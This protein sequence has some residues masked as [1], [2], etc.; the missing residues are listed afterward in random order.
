MDPP[1]YRPV[2]AGLHLRHLDC[3]KQ[4]PRQPAPRRPNRRGSPSHLVRLVHHQRV[5]AL[6]ATNPRLRH[7]QRGHRHP[8]DDAGLH[9][10][11]VRGARILPVPPHQRQ[12]QL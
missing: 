3:P 7:R 6:P 8:G 5:P 2:P 1:S 11:R 10:P 12:R 4:R 9:R